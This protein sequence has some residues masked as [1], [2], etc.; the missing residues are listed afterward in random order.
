M[1]LSKAARQFWSDQGWPVPTPKPRP[2]KKPPR[3]PKK[4]L[5]AKRQ[6]AFLADCA[7]SFEEGIAL[8]RRERELWL[9]LKAL[10]AGAPD[11][12]KNIPIWRNGLPG[13]MQS[14]IG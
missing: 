7:R 10:W 9:K 4:P 13:K 11:L 2:P 12:E 14:I 6:R 3:P 1:N 8:D 5:S